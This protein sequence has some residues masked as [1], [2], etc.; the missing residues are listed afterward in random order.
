M[1]EHSLCCYIP[2]IK[3]ITVISALSFIVLFCKKI[4]KGG[5]NMDMRLRGNVA[6]EMDNGSIGA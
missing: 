3:G 4:R 5:R 6:D 2:I 1:R